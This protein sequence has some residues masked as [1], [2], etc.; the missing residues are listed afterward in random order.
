MGD[1]MKYILAA[2]ALLLFAIQARAEENTSDGNYLLGSCQI[3]IRGY[4]TNYVKR[5]T[6]LLTLI[7]MVTVRV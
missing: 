7:G 4:D 1:D 6:I 3:S 2:V 5:P